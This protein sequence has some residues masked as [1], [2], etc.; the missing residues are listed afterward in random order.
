MVYNLYREGVMGMRKQ[1]LYRERANASK[2]FF[3]SLLAILCW[4]MFLV[5]LIWAGEKCPTTSTPAPAPDSSSHTVPERPPDAKNTPG[6]I[7]DTSF[8]GIPKASELAEFEAGK[9]IK[10]GDKEYIVEKTDSGEINFKEIVRSSDKPDTTSTT[11]TRDIEY[12]KRGRVISSTEEVHSD[13][14]P[15]ITNPLQAGLDTGEQ[16]QRSAE[17][18]NDH[19]DDRQNLTEEMEALREELEEMMEEAEKENE[20]LRKA[21]EELKKEMEELIKEKEMEEH[22]REMAEEMEEMREKMKKIKSMQELKNKDLV[23]RAIPL[24]KEG[25]GKEIIYSRDK[26][27]LLRNT[28]KVLQDIM[29]ELKSRKVN[30]AQKKQ[31]ADYTIW[32]TSA[33]QRLNKVA[34]NWESDSKKIY[35]GSED[36]MMNTRQMAEMNANFNLQFLQLQ[37]E[38]QQESQRYTAIS[39][40]M[41]TRHDTVKNVIE[42][43]R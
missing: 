24:S 27:S 6:D 21:M 12:D 9:I 42:N 11:K 30:D 23:G 10:I 37:Q 29:A 5:S 4:G 36:P 26:I 22:R 34:A 3:Q 16:V 28:A 31:L 40:I 20:E 43:L 41:K 15:A 39:N 35:N 14:V 19:L 7:G 17:E 2:I 33:I 32:L 18:E 8:D 1:N 25:P 38:L 13:S